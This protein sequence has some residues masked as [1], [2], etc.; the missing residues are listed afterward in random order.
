[1]STNLTLTDVL[2]YLRMYMQDEENID[3]YRNELTDPICAEDLVIKKDLFEK[4]SPEAKEIIGLLIDNDPDIV[5][6]LKT[7][8]KKQ[9]S[10]KLVRRWIHR[11]YPNKGRHI[12]NELKRLASA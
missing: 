11:R 5:G 1:M 8:V 2:Y 12:V 10:R 3:H 9:Y 6:E 7:K 4:A